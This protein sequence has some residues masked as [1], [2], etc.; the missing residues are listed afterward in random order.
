MVPVRQAGD[1]DP[2]EVRH[3][4]L[5]RLGLF[6][7]AIGQRRGYLARFDP[8]EDGVLLG[9]LQVIGDPVDELVP[10]ATERVWIHQEIW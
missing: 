2:F 6:G 4:G 10:R 7:C 1:E 9:M 8:G 5:E 3:D